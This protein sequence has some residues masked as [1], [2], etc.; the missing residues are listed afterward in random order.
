MEKVI[1]EKFEALTM[2][3]LK[4]VWMETETDNSPEIATVRGWIMDE[5]ERRDA[6]GFDLFL[7]T[8]DLESIN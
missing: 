2:E 7:L 5:F 3:Q 4:S 8:N 1:A 6:E